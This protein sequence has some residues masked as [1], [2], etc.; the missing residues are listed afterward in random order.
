MFYLFY[1]RA[2]FFA[3]IIS[4]KFQRH[5]HSICVWDMIKQ[6]K[7]LQTRY[8]TTYIY[9]RYYIRTHVYVLLFSVKKRVFEL[10]QVWP[11]RWP[12]GG[13]P[14]MEFIGSV[15]HYTIKTCL[16][17]VGYCGYEWVEKEMCR[18]AEDMSSQTHCIYCLK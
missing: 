4:K 18:F 7:P 8:D 1:R 13:T 12:H 6:S 2:S 9:D 10:S 3:F 14:Y 16:K 11:W 17:R 5:M 15:F